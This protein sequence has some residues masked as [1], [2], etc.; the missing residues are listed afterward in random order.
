MVA[1]RSKALWDREVLPTTGSVIFRRCVTRAGD[2]IA[3]RTG[4]SEGEGRNLCIMLVYTIEYDYDSY[5]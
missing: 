1:V 5:H 4:R 3:T 2:R